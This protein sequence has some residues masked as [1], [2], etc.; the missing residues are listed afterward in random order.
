M[1][2]LHDAALMVR[3]TQAN[4]AA[5]FSVY[6]NSPP[7]PFFLLVHTAAITHKQGRLEDV[8]RLVRAEGHDINER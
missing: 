5:P 2:R 4:C 1:G 7:H 3:C 6:T 8:I